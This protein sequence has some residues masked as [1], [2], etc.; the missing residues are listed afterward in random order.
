MNDAIV[1]EF[2]WQCAGKHHSVR[3]QLDDNP[4]TVGRDPANLLVLSD[5]SVSRRHAEIVLTAHGPALCDLQSRFG[6]RLEQQLSAPLQPLLLPQYCELYFGRQKVQLRYDAVSSHEP[7][8]AELALQDLQLRFSRMQQQSLSTLQQLSESPAL[9]TQLQQELSQQFHELQQAALQWTQQNSLLQRLNTLVHNT[10]GYLVLLEHTVPMIAEAIG[11]ER[12]FV[13]MYDRRDSRYQLHSCWNYPQVN[14]LHS[15]NP[16][17]FFS[18]RLARSCYEQPRLQLAT[19]PQ[20]L[21]TLHCPAHSDINAVLTMPLQ[22]NNDVL[23]VLY[24]D[25]R[26]PEGFRA[27]T[28]MFCKTLQCQLGLALKNAITISRALCDDL[29]GLC[30]R[31]MIEEQ[32]TLAMEQAKRYQ[33]PCSLIF[34]DLDDFKQIND[35]YGHFAGDEVLRSVAELLRTL[36]RKADRVGRLGGEEFVVLVH[37]TNVESATVYAERIRADIAALSL[38]IGGQALSIS[39]S[40]G[41]AGYYHALHNL[42]YRFIDCADQAMYQAKRGGKNRVCVHQPATLQLLDTATDLLRSGARG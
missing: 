40:I 9:L 1:L 13:L 24:L 15:D 11:A 2:D 22:H 37:H 7:D 21:Q 6:T 28:E 8:F 34:I 10:Q 16:E 25:S 23:A 39:A 12:G 26:Q 3:L 42:A 32:I 31:S 17:V 36:V 35:Q 19:D 29:T 5:S 18:Q 41:V 4:L 38:D 20:R 14:Q 27:L 33:H 30:S